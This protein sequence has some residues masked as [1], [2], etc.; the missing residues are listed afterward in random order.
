MTKYSRHAGVILHPSSLPGNNGIGEFGDEAKK[1]IDWM[2]LAGQSIWQVMPLGPTGY[3]DSPYQCFSSFA[4]N[5]LFISLDR[6]VEDELLSQNDLINLN[7]LDK[8]F[9]DYGSVIPEKNRLYKIAYGNFVKSDSSTKASFYNFCERFDSWLDDYSTFMAIKED[10]GGKCWVNWDKGVRDRDEESLLEV[11]NRLENEIKYQKWIQFI[12][13]EQWW[14]IRHYANEKGIEIIGDLPLFVAY[15]SVDV[16]ANRELF[17]LDKNGNSTVVAGVPPDYFSKTGQLWGN[18]LYKWEKHVETRFSW[19]I[20]RVQAVR[21]FVDIIRIDHFRG[22]SQYWEI[23]AEENTAENGRWV[24]A[25]GY[26]LFTTIRDRLGELP[27]IAEDLGVIDDAV[28]KLRDNFSFPGMKVLQFAWGGE[29]DNP[30]LPHNHVTNS[31][32][33]TGTHDN[34]TTRGWYEKEADGKIKKHIEKYSGK[35]IEDINEEFYRIAMSSIARYSIAPL[36]DILNLDVTSR[37]NTPGASQGNWSWRCQ[38]QDLTK[39]VAKRI[40]DI[41]TVYGRNI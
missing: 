13:I 40:F 34:N 33:Y 38:K 6:L 29:A 11:K 36:Q 27:F 8:S 17:E 9:V 15:D 30:F 18:P 37:M 21:T 32:V 7:R 20:E 41:S 4:M 2:K 16:W 10:N 22:L 23:S 25:P 5:P 14:E 1:F 28:E 39:K 35:E 26:E 24:E 19:W 31:V 3:G 12:V